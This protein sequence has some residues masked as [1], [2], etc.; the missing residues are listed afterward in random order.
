MIATEGDFTLPVPSA[1]STFPKP[2]P[3][4]L[5]RTAKVPVAKLSTRDPMSANAGRFSLSM[6]GMRKE[7]RRARGR[8]ET[9]VRI[10]EAEMTEWLQ[11]GVMLLPNESNATGLANLQ[12]TPGQGRTIESTRIVELSRS[13]LQLIWSMTCDPFAR[14]VVHCC[15]RYHE[16]VSFSE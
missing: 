8:T 15:A 10:V 2:L 6:K 5:L 7:L 12:I 16:V 1:K 3:S 11:G 14:Y 9:L 4:Y 13:P